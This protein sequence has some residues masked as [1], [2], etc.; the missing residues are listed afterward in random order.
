MTCCPDHARAESPATTSTL[1]IAKEKPA[2]GPSV[3]VDEGYM[4]P[5][6]FRIP[7]TDKS[8]EMVP[9][10]GGTYLMG[11]PESEADRRDDEGPQ[12]KVTVDPM[13]VAKHEVRWGLYK[14]YMEL[15]G[16]F[17]SFEASGKRPIDDANKVDAITAPTE[18][19]DST[20]TYEYGEEDEQ[21]AVTMTQ[22]S[23]Q[24]FTKWISLV[25]GQQYRLP[26]E[27][28]WEYAARGGTQTAYSWGDSADDIDDYAWYFD[29]ADEG[30]VAGGQKKPNPFGLFDM[31]G[32]VGEW[33]VN[34]YTEDGYARFADQS[35]LNATEMAVWPDLPSPCVVRGG[36]WESDA[37][38]LRSAARLPSDDE[39]WKSEDPNFPRSPW[40]FTS[41]PARGVGFRIFRSYKP[42]AKDTITKFWEAQSEDVKLDVQSRLD[43]GRGGLGLVDKDLPE[44]IEAAKK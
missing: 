25:T 24:Q 15:Y 6:T 44:A 28:E 35:D 1:G 2:E 18:L 9:V 34:A 5:Y 21:P 39:E 10:P 29:N 43:G 23:A 3:K 36:T 20:F 11:S 13:W 40:W 38:D 8:V 42:L 41:D 7:G 16:I 37:E 19:Y 26:T 4:V 27:A 14:E 31:H 33:T 17:K 30:Q 12:V 32:N 22:Y